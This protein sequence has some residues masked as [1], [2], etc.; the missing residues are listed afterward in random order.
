MSSPDGAREDEVEYVEVLA[1]VAEET[2]ELKKLAHEIL[3]VPEGGELSD[4]QIQ[5]ALTALCKIY[6]VHY[7]AGGRYA[8]FVGVS[9][10]PP[11]V[12]MVMASQMLKAVNVE[13][14]E[15]G[16]WQAWSRG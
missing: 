5:R 6:T 3:A 11:T 7:Q 16:M 10:L 9:G 1:D 4:E 8:P 12:V 14:F 15:L 13:L 2:A